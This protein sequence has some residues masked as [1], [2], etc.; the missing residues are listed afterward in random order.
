MLVKILKKG[1][2]LLIKMMECL[3][4]KVGVE[5]EG[6]KYETILV[7]SLTKSKSLMSNIIKEIEDILVVY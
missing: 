6:I 1:C 3:K 4:M 2:G 7:I 5:L